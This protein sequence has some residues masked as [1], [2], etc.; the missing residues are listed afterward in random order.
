MSGCFTL[1]ILKKC[2]EFN[3]IP[4]EINY[5]F[6]MQERKLQI[7]PVVSVKSDKQLQDSKLTS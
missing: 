1:L 3:Y 7:N 2:C 5:Y 4:S 6:E